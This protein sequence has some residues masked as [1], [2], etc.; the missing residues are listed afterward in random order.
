MSKTDVQSGESKRIV[1]R[2]HWSALTLATRLSL[3]LSDLI[4]PPE[5]SNSHSQR[6]VQYSDHYRLAFT[7]MNEN[8]T[9]R[10]FV[11]TWDI[12]YALAGNLHSLVSRDQLKTLYQNSYFP[13]CPNSP[14]CTISQSKVRSSITLHWLLSQNSSPMVTLKYPVLLGRT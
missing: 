12:Q 5:S 13:F 10:R 4:A 6:I 11:D 3:L 9:L 2:M 7:L 14:F 8:A 1:V